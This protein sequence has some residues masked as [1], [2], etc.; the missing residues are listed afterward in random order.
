VFILDSDV[1]GEVAEVT[2]FPFRLPNE[3]A[4]FGF[5]PKE[6]D[7]EPGDLIMFEPKSR[8]KLGHHMIKFVQSRCYGEQHSRWTHAA[9]YLGDWRVCTA[10]PRRG[11]HTHEIWEQLLS[12]RLRVRRPKLPLNQ[13][14]QIVVNALARKGEKYGLSKLI[15]FY[16]EL[17]R[18]HNVAA[19]QRIRVV[20]A[21]ICSDLYA[22]AF[23]LASHM[24]VGQPYNTAFMPA[25]LSASDKLVD[26]S[27]RWARLS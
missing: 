11:V 8:W 2:S 26:V 25:D 1:K 22:D 9:V 4:H 6:E 23:F 19:H 16:R 14:F 21:A 27:V 7:L 12:H 3:I 10:T 17:D 18:L 24:V 5:I 13:R 20:S 15:A